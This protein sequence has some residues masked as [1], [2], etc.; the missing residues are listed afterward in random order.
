M[1][2]H[3]EFVTAFKDVLTIS[4]QMA[5]YDELVTAPR[6]VFII[7]SSDASSGRFNDMTKE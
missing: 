3:D 1:A 4:R 7:F 5:S 2:S 6:D